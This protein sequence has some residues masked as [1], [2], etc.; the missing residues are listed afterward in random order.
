MGCDA[1]RAGVKG[2]ISAWM[3]ALLVLGACACLDLRVTPVQ[4]DPMFSAGL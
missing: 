3:K 2:E 4:G 1:A